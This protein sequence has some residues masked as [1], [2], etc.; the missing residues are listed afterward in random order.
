MENT[1]NTNTAA[2]KPSGLPTTP[3]GAT[4]EQSA[5]PSTDAPV[6]KG[7]SSWKRA[8]L[9]D[10]KL[11]D[12]YKDK[13]HLHW[14][15]KGNMVRKLDEGYVPAQ[16][17]QLENYSAGT[18]QDSKKGNIDAPIQRREMTLCVLSQ[19]GVKERAIAMQENERNPEEIVDEFASKINS[20]G[21]AHAY[22]ELTHDGRTSVRK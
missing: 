21:D 10:A 8:G 3:Q 12:D 9:L 7:T 1:A 20:K 19:E 18:I 6:K 5:Q 11:K 14:V 2:P 17:E 15:R 13:L 16:P 22:S 4:P